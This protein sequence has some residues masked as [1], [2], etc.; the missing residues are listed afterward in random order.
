GLV[1]RVGHAQLPDQH[2]VRRV[3]DVEDVDAFEARADELA[4]AGRARVRGR[5]PGPD[6]DVAPYHDV[7]L[8]A[9][10]GARR[11]VDH[12]DRVRRV[13]VVDDPEAVV[14]AL[15]GELALEGE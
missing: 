10:A 4:A 15:E 9:G 12:L 14:R 6:E 3:R 13:G 11:V 5:V 1:P 2:R 7:A 8:A